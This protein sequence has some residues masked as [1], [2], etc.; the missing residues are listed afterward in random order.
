MPPKRKPINYRYATEDETED[1]YEERPEDPTL[2]GGLPENLNMV[3]TVSRSGRIM[4]TRKVK[5]TRT[6]KMNRNGEVRSQ[7]LIHPALIPQI[8]KMLKRQGT[9]VTVALLQILAAPNGHEVPL[10]RLCGN[11]RNGVLSLRFPKGTGAPMLFAVKSTT[12]SLMTSARRDIVF[13]TLIL[14]GGQQLWGM[15]S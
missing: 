10:L 6:G 2:S 5:K 15:E 1:E 9:V 3:R 13:P 12:C 7:N 8:K 4:T 14:F 11:G